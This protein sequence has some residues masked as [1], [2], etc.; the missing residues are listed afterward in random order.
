MAPEVSEILEYIMWLVWMCLTLTPA[1]LK[2]P[3][4]ALVLST[5]EV[6]EE[7]LSAWFSFAPGL[8]DVLKATTPPTI[9]YF[10][11]LLT[12][13]KRRWAVYLLV[14]EKLGSRPKIYIGPG[15]YGITGATS[16]FN[17][18]DNKTSLPRYVKCALDDGYTILHKG[19][20][21]WSPIPP[22]GTRFIV[23][24]LFLAIEA[25]FSIVLWAMKS[26]TKDYGMPHLCP[27]P[28]ED[29]E[30]DG[31][32]SHSALTE[33]IMSETENLTPEQIA[34]KELEMDQRRRAA[35]LAAYY[36]LK[37]LDFEKW[38][39]SRRATAKKTRAK[40]KAGRK[41]AC[42]LC[43]VTFADSTEL[44]IHN[45]TNKHIAKANGI[46][47]LKHP[48]QA[49]AHKTMSAANILAKKHHCGICNHSFGTQQ[50]LN[51]HKMTQKHK[52]RAAKAAKSL[53]S[54]S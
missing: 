23:R 54:S 50:Q 27:W 3:A 38:Q 43:D 8:L 40:A 17:Q 32:C 33:N 19:T 10:K 4:F 29:I 26:R 35:N 34:A 20:L 18:Y 13:V 14:L 25:T 47:R 48:L 2:N 28:L 15:T 24:T 30:Y 39:T 6:L 16:R 1:L 5:E 12:E 31:C 9:A 7:I 52:D 51:K 44:N 49:A 11:T 36:D 45:G 37:H 22:L 46:N 42:D 41:F 53:K 21:C